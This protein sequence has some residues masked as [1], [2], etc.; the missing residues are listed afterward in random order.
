MFLLAC[1]PE[2]SR[3]PDGRPGDADVSP[4]AGD[5]D[6]LGLDHYRSGT[7]IKT[8]VMGTPDGAKVYMGNHD[9]MRGDDC[10]FVLA[11]DGTTR[12]LP[13]DRVF[14]SYFADASCTI[15]AASRPACAPAPKYLYDY[16]GTCPGEM[17]TRIFA[18]GARHSTAYQLSGA[19]CVTVPPTGVVYYAAGPEVPPSEFVPGT[20]SIE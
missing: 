5:A 1:A 20:K 19:N 8:I 17:G 18:R 3:P 13:N 16:T 4:D 15:P 14:T 11:T 2:S 12:C 10:M 6:D 7:R 9:V